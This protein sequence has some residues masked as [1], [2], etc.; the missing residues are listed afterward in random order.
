[1]ELGVFIPIGNNGWLISTTSP[2]YKPTF[3]LNREVVQKAERF[4]FDFALS[5]IKLHGFGG[6]S[7][8][9]DYNLEI[10]H[11][12][13]RAGVG[14]EPHPALRHLRRPD[15]AA[16][17]RR[18]HG[19]DD[20]LDLARPVRRQHHLRL[21]AA[22]IHADGDLARRRA[23]PAPLRVLR[24]IRH[25][26]ARAVG[27]R[28]LRLQGRF[29]PD[30][31][32][33]LSAAAD[34]RRSRSSAPRRAMPA[35]ALPRNTPTTISAPAAASTS[36][37]RWRRASRAWSK[38]R[39]ETGR[40]CGALIL[41]M[42]IADETDAAAM[43]KW[44]HYKAGTDLE[45]LAWR[46]AQAEDDPSRDPYSQPNRRRTLGVDRSADEPGRVCRLLCLRRADARRDGDAC[47][48][49]AA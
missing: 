13:G 8:F 9:W 11:A 17:D 49:C 48:A 39:H 2:Q 12:D 28:P 38:R 20:R 15:D 16:A 40:D 45:A 26:H 14:D 42:V 37:E 43:A 24:R 23:L 22:R 19:G 31:R 1:M 30:G 41:Q 4:G 47:P 6:P 29:L 10:V 34:A 27:G 25:H 3:D 21:A 18:P 36:R 7:Q 32:L 46:D 33:P 5:M 44:E 35:P